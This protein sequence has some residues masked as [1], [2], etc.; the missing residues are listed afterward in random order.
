MQAGTVLVR[1]GADASDLLRTLRGADAS[2]TKFA[3][4]AGAV[5]GAAIAAGMGVAT[6]AVKKT[7]NEMDELYMLSQRIALPVEQLSA[8]AHA[9]DLS[10]T[11]LNDMSTAM[12]K[13]SSTMDDASK[14]GSA[15]AIAFERI[16]L[17]AEKLKNMSN[18]EVLLA[19]ADSF[20]QMAD[21]ATKSAIAVELLGRGGLSMIPMLN[22]G[23]ESLKRMFEEAKNLGLVVST[24]AAKAAEGFNDNLTRLGAV[25]RGLLTQFTAGLSP[26]LLTFSERLVSTSNATDGAYRAGQLFGDWLVALPGKIMEAVTFTQIFIR[27]MEGLIKA[28]MM[29]STMRFGGAIEELKEMAKD[30]NALRDSFEKARAEAEY[31]NEVLRVRAEHARQEREEKEKANRTTEEGNVLTEE[32]IK[33]REE[34]MKQGEDYAQSLRDQGDAMVEA[35]Q[36]PMEEYRAKLAEI[37]ALQA[38]GAINADTSARAQVMAAATVAN[39]YASVASQAA[40]A[41]AGLFEDNKAVAIAAA[42]INTLEGITAAFKLPP[43][44]NWIQAAAVA[45]AGFAQVRRIRATN[46]GSGGGGSAGNLRGPGGSSGGGGGGGDKRSG[47]DNA[48]TLGVNIILTGQG[49]FTR[50]QVRGLAG[51]LSELTADGAVIGQVSVV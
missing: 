35:T 47:S 1:I 49:G 4:T 20:S 41:L 14:A 11:S 15:S 40:D 42:I 2:F 19:M 7:L 32:E 23:S 46:P 12:R 28:G 6:V 25:V 21:G 13:L 51:Q 43:P 26:A 10:G 16:G 29:A 37:Q 9:A 30:S 48:N 5:A 38:Q 45:A 31:M 24:D 39:A 36:G 22:E 33:Q 50:D 18:H 34:L 44:L 8:W 17:S 3:R 27:V